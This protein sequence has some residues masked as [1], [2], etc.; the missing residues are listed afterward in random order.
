M[1]QKTAVIVL[2]E[3]STDTLI[4]TQRSPDLKAHPGEFCFPGGGFERGDVDLWD[5]ALRELWEELGIEASRVCLMN[6]LKPEETRNGRVIIPWLASV[7]TLTPFSMNEL[8]VTSILRLPLSKVTKNKYYKT[9]SLVLED[10]IIKTCQ[11]TAT[12]E[13]VWGAT[14][15]IMKQLCRKRHVF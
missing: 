15:R 3:R 7:E 11:F 5:T 8:E 1:T 14:A 13:F 9:I 12:S 10:K 6:E 4:L 2:W